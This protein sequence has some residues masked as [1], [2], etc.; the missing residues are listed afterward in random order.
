M[1]L[2]IY[3]FLLDGHCVADSVHAKSEYA[4]EIFHTHDTRYLV[5]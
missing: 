3:R 2:G 1:K 4:T 5:R